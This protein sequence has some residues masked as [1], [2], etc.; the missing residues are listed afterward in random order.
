MT[1][2]FVILCFLLR[3]FYVYDIEKNQMALKKNEMS[4][5]LTYLNCSALENNIGSGRNKKK[6]LTGTCVIMAHSN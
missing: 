5:K 1:E 4:A 3:P 2:A 6:A